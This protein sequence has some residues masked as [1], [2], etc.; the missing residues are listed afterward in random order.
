MNGYGTHTFKWVNEAGD[1][2]WIKYHIHAEGGTK[3]LKNEVANR[4]KGEDPDYNTR[5]LYNHIASGKEAVWIMKVQIMPAAQGLTYKWDI[6]D[7]TKIWP[8]ADYPVQ[9]VGR[10]VLNRNPTNY[11]AEVEQAAFN[12]GHFVPGI[13]PSMDRILQ[14]RILSYPDTHRHRLG[15]NF[16]QI[17]VNCPYMA[18]VAHYQRDG[19]MTSNGNFGGEPNYEPNT[20]EGTPKQDLSTARKEFKVEGT[21]GRHPFKHANNDFEQP[22][23]M[24]RKVYD[25]ETKADLIANITGHMKKG[26]K[27]CTIERNL[28]IFYKCDPEY[29]AKA[30]QALQLPVHQAKL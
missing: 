15:S 29:K 1:E 19:P 24:Y 17:P 16:M 18:R 20:V 10:L 7:P 12:P 27:R 13:E 11:F 28:E 22:G 23:V 25:D 30:A 2:F 21:A 9:S 4:L 3:N 5:D 8:H 26:A 14:G 6:F